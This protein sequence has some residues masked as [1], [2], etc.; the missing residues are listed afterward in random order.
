MIDD[1]GS[2]FDKAKNGIKEELEFLKSIHA[3][4]EM[5]EECQQRYLQALMNYNQYYSNKAKFLLELASMN[6]MDV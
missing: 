1:D 2:C 5:I 3:S 6:E 4:E